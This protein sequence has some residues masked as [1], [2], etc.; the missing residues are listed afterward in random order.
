MTRNDPSRRPPRA[1]SPGLVV[2][3]LSIYTRLTAQG[4]RLPTFVANLGLRHDSSGMKMAFVLTVSDLFNS[5][6]EHTVIDTPVL[7][8]DIMRRRSSRIVYAGFVYSFGHPAK[9]AKDDALQFD[10][11]F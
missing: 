8:D 1:L 9:K 10:N 5:L 2:V 11:Q 4:Y 6:R 3:E 7:H